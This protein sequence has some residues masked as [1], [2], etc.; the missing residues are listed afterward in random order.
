MH[1]HEDTRSSLSYLELVSVKSGLSSQRTGCLDLNKS[2]V[3]LVQQDR[4]DKFEFQ[5]KVRQKHLE[6]R[7]KDKL[8]RK[9]VPVS[10]FILY[11]TDVPLSMT[12]L[13]YKQ[14][15]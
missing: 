12:T 13:F 2:S 3:K 7:K 8:K 1:D 4:Q 14:W 10:T 11:K 15:D 6:K 9:R 5:E